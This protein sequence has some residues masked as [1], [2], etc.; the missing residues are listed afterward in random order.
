MLSSF[1]ELSFGWWS[2]H[3][4]IVLLK[5]LGLSAVGNNHLLFLLSELSHHALPFTLEDS[6]GIDLRQ[7]VHPLDE[8]PS[9]NE[10]LDLVFHS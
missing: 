3:V 7:T 8:Q 6:I 2:E 5:H 1:H 10:P 4:V 9:I